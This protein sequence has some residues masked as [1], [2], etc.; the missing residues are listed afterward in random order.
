MSLLALLQAACPELVAAV[1]ARKSTAR[2]VLTTPGL[3][4][5]LVHSPPLFAAIAK[6]P[7]LRTV[8]GGEAAGWPV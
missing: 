7:K 2:L 5:V 1:Q 4:E 6:D 8:L 3:A